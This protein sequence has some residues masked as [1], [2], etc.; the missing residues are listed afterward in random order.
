VSRTGLLVAGGAIVAALA[1][2]VLDA[3]L[4]ARAAGARQESTK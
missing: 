1:I 4:D 2:T 3:S